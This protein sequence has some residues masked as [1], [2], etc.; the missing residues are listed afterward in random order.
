MKQRL[1]AITV[2]KQETKNSLEVPLSK[3]N[4]LVNQTVLLID[5]VSSAGV[6]M[7]DSI[8]KLR[9]GGFT[10]VGAYSIVYRGLGANLVAKELDVPFKYLEYIPENVV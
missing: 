5:D 2:R 6:G 3:P 4:R 1:P 10:V 7:Q 8:E 9:E